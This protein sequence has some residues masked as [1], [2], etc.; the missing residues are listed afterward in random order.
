MGPGVSFGRGVMFGGMDLTTIS[1][2]DLEIE[3]QGGT[4]VIKGHY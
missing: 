2:R 3:E 1:G 4:A